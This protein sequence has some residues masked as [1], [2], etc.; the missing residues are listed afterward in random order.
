LRSIIEGI[1]DNKGILV[2]QMSLPKR[3]DAM[4]EELNLPGSFVKN[5][6]SYRFMG[7]Y[8]LHKLSP[9][10]KEDLLLAIEVIEDLLNFLYE[11]DYKASLLPDE[12]KLRPPR[13]KVIKLK[14]EKKRD[15]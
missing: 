9:P 2:N 8:A 7:K 1:C 14:D 3:I 13:A 11:L 5:L 12:Q 6:H 15:K 4:E 10:V